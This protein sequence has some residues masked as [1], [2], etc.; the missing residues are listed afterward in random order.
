[1]TQSPTPRTSHFYRTL[2][3]LIAVAV[4]TLMLYSHAHAQATATETLLDQAAFWQSQRHPDQAISSLARVLAFDPINADALAMLSRIQAGEGHADAA[5]TVLAR[6][7][8]SHPDDRRVVS[9]ERSLGIEPSDPEPRAPVTPNPGDLRLQTQLDAAVVAPLAQVAEPGPAGPP[10]LAIAAPGPAT[11]RRATTRDP[12]RPIAL[13]PAPQD[14]PLEQSRAGRQRDAFQSDIAQVLRGDPA[15][16]RNRLLALAATPDASGANG[17]A[18][19]SQFIKLG[20]RASARDAVQ[21]ALA[22]AKTPTGEQ[23][24]ASANALLAAGYDR[25]AAMALGSTD[26]AGLAGDERRRYEG[27]QNSLAIETSDAWNRAGDQAS[28]Y[29]ALSPRL[30]AQPAAA[31]LNLALGRLYRSDHRPREALRIDEALLS[32]TPN[33][34]DVRR[35]AVDAAVQAGDVGRARAMVAEAIRT[36]PRDPRTYM[37]SADLAQARGDDGRA[38]S[39][40]RRARSLRLHQTGATHDGAGS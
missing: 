8:A 12:G 25:D 32:Q 5:R 36:A 16:V 40:L 11:P 7:K 6:L 19:A 18:I 4:V 15:R 30:T 14:R 21:V 31:D 24:L 26:P 28:A 1:M 2:R 17:T 34:L 20:D 35:A 27:L 38:L 22:A 9:L 33:D 13:A 3:A 23:R 37:M 29:E 10:A 39:D